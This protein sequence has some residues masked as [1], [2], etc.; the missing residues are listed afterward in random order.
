MNKLDEF[1]Q[2][3]IKLLESSL[4]DGK[5]TFKE[6][7][8]AFREKMLD[9]IFDVDALEDIANK[10]FV[11]TVLPLIMSNQF[12]KESE[13]NIQHILKQFPE[14]R[15]ILKSVTVQLDYGDDIDDLGSIFVKTNDL[16]RFKI[17]L[18]LNSICYLM[19]ET[20]LKSFRSLSKNQ[21][22][23]FIVGIIKVLIHEFV[24]FLDYFKRS[25]DY[26]LKDFR[27]HYYLQ[28]GELRA[29]TREFLF[30]FVKDNGRQLVA[31]SKDVETFLNLVKLTRAYLTVI[32][33]NLIEPNENYYETFLKNVYDYF[34]SGKNEFGESEDETNSQYVFYRTVKASDIKDIKL[35]DISKQTAGKYSELLYSNSFKN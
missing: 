29:H 16:Q 11:E 32:K 3:F 22:E 6:S 20:S 25:P 21:N 1:K 13:I 10:V 28:D 15:G 30:Q 4:K 27:K 9:M 5:S 23:Q 12:S 26:L 35:S 24:H 7:E 33:P 34:K 2:L 31:Q 14:T 8:P 17:T 18:L 19:N